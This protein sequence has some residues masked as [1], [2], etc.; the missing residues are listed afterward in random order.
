MKGLGFPDP[1]SF[2]VS[3]FCFSANGLGPMVH[4]LKGKGHPFQNTLKYGFLHSNSM[5]IIIENMKTVIIGRGSVGTN[6][7]Y[8]LRNVPGISF[9][10]DKEREFRTRS[11]IVF[12][13]EKLAVP[14]IVAEDTQD[15]P[16]LIVVAVKNFQLESTFP[17]IEPLLGE[18][19]IILPLLNG[20]D[21]ERILSERFGSERV[22][23][24]FI[25]NLSVVREGNRVSSFSK[26]R[27]TMGEKDNSLSERILKLRDF[28]LSNGQDVVIPEDIHHEKWLKFMTNTCFN[29]L[30]AILEA[31]Y[32]A[33]G[34]NMDMIRVARLV[35]REVQNVG[36]KMGVEL[37]HDDVETMIRNTSKLSGKGRSSMLEDVLAGRETENRYFTGAVSRMG[38]LY[39]IPTPYCDMLSILLEAK[40]YVANCH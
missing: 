40:R 31:D 27:I 23:Y 15:K 16:E 13:G 25:S 14:T 24:A 34:N 36:R 26:G 20:I 28:F 32:D 19:T 37:S 7:A 3:C 12:N 39:S 5:V 17:V 29:T 9:R 4:Q 1:F 22:V 8:N 35:A 18:N 33:T 21:S 2:P 38:K 11:N 30:T 6:V 10:V